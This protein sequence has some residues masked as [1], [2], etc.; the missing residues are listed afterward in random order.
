MG[1]STPT[2]KDSKEN[3]EQHWIF[4][5]IEKVKTPTTSKKQLF[6]DDEE[7]QKKK[8]PSLN[9]DIPIS[10]IAV[11]KKRAIRKQKKEKQK[12]EDD[13]VLSYIDV[14]FKRIQEKADQERIQKKERKQSGSKRKHNNSGNKSMN[15]SV[16]EKKPKR[17][18]NVVD[19]TPEE[20][21]EIENFDLQIVVV[22]KVQESR[23]QGEEKSK[24]N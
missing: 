15:G 6:K 4:E 16:N 11:K 18:S 24:E 23:S 21:A 9:L 3:K 5:K 22:P 13:D 19:L 20:I 1:Q 14:M 8:S 12:T 7:N 10:P 17:T 2:R